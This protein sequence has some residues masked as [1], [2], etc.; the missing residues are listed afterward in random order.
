MKIYYK[1]LISFLI[2]SAGRVGRTFRVQ[3]PRTNL[4]DFDPDSLSFGEDPNDDT[5]GRPHPDPK[6]E[7]ELSYNEIKDARW[8]YDTPGIM[9]DQD[10]RASC[11]SESVCVCVCDCFYY[12]VALS[13]DS[14]S[15]E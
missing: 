13:T 11:C 10:V 3:S 9:K 6:P 8:F 5:W 7:S 4:V 12:V 15:A 1:C 2:L 14:E